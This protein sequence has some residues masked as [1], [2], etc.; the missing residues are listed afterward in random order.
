[1]NE[2]IELVVNKKI[3]KRLHTIDTF[4]AFENDVTI[5]GKD[6]FGNDFTINFDAYEF[7]SWLDHDA[8]KHIKK[9]LIKYIKTNL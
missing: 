6:E 5:S 8:M 1:M 2:N 7:L 9:T 3:Q 4:H